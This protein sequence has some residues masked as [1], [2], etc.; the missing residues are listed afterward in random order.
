L[1][2]VAPGTSLDVVLRDVLP[3]LC[4]SLIDMLELDD[5]AESMI[6]FD[7]S[8]LVATVRFSNTKYM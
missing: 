6:T 5:V 8:S 4:R 3:T 1:A 7:V 2:L